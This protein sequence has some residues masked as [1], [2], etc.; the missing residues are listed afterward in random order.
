MFEPMMEMSDDAVIKVVGIGGGGGNAV[1]HMVRESI[2]GVDFISIN[3]DAQALRKSSVGTVIQIGGDITKGL[4]A[5]A[6]PQVGRD[7]ALED[8]D[9]I[10][11]ELEGAD[12]VFIAAGMGGGTGTGGAPVIAEIAK[13]MGILTVAVVT[14]PFSFEGKKRLAFAEQGIE[15]LSKQ[16]DSLITI[17]NEKLLKVLGRGITLLDAFAKANDVLRNAVQGIAEL[18]TRP[19]HINVD[20]AD[21]RTVMSEMG[22]AMMGSGVATGE[23]RAEEA[24]EMAISSPLLED[25]DLAGARGVLVNIT[26]GFDMRL[27]E[28]ETVGNTVKA[29]ASDNA[30]V[31]IGTSMDPEMSDELRVTVVATGIGNERK[32]DITLVT[33]AQSGQA[34]AEPKKAQPL[35]DKPQAASSNPAAKEQPAASS[36]AAPKS[37]TEHDYLDIPAFLRKQAD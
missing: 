23:D 16:V 8:R 24:A 26:A 29:F 10:K 18:I 20:F 21:V 3:T 31:V 14:K 28:F 32:P 2:E 25:I 22:H 9:A 19:G 1:E 6:N 15:E 17:P 36:N 35:Q 13:E 7:S 33:N 12:M 37:Q 4:G 11:A 27:D 5:G 30:T 34:K